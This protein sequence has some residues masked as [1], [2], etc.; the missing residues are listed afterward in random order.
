MASNLLLSAFDAASGGG[1]TGDVRLYD[2][3]GLA[4]GGTLCERAPRFRLRDRGLIWLC[5]TDARQELVPMRPTT[6]GRPVVADGDDGAVMG[7]RCRCRVA[8]AA[9]AR[10]PWRTVADS[11]VAPC[12][13]WRTSL[14][15]ARALRPPVVNSFRSCL[16]GMRI[17]SRF[18]GDSRGVM[19]L[20]VVPSA[21]GAGDAAMAALL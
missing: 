6:R 15:D 13:E 9:R 3:R 10:L 18:L 8:H 11:L 4:C 19:R 7:V 20:A 17:S 1:G 16:P 21:V 12:G 5:F 14:R 2:K